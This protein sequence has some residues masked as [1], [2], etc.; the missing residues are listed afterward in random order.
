VSEVD[1][2]GASDCFCGVFAAALTGDLSEGDALRWAAARAALLV[3]C[4]G[5]QT[6]VPAAEEIEAFL[7]MR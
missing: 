5:A 3:T 1:T 4:R 7:S 6:S 2:V